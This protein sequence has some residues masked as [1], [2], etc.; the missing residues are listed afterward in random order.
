[1][2]NCLLYSRM[3]SGFPSNDEYYD[4]DVNVY[5][6]NLLSSLIYPEY[7]M[8]LNKYILLYD[9]T[10]FEKVSL[11]K[12][13]R[14]KYLTYKTNADFMLLSLGIFKNPCRTRPNSVPYMKLSKKS[15]TG[16]GK[17]YY[18]LAQS[19]CTQT[20]RKNT[21]VGEILGKL[22][23]GFEKYANVLSL[24]RGE[25]FNIYKRFTGGEMYHLERS[26]EIIDHKKNL[27]KLHDKFL[28]A[29]SSYMQNK[30]DES[31][32]LLEEITIEIRR[33]DPSFQFSI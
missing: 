23:I 21:A 2:M 18:N 22:S 29:Y 3:E 24:M 20:F 1:M 12:N 27:S 13:P 6:A 9:T 31:K 30:T 33:L 11:T 32:K 15:Y 8:M 17:T 19:Y 16:R 5:L 25:Y 28:D 7:H 26:I 10:L 4:E 14:T